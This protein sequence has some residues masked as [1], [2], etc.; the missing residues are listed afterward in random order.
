MTQ[1]EAARPGPCSTRAHRPR[2]PGRSATSSPTCC[3][4]A[5]TTCAPGAASR[6]R[7]GCCLEALQELGVA[8][9]L[10]RASL[11]IGC[12]TSFSSDDRRRPRAGAARARPVGRHRREAHAARHG[13][14]HPAGRRRHGER[15]AAGGAAHRRARRARHL[16][17]AEQRRVRRDRRAHDRD[18]RASAS[19]PRTR[20]TGATPSTTATRSSSAT[21]SRGLR[22]RRTWRAARCTTRARWRGR[23]GCASGRSR[24]SSTAR[25][26]RS[27]RCSPCA[28]PGGSSRPPRG[29]DYMHDTLGEV[30]IMGELKVD[31]V[32]KTTE[33]LHEENVRKQRE[34][35]PALA[36]GGIDQLDG[37]RLPAGGRGVPRR[38]PGVARRAPDAGA[39]CAADGDRVHARDR[40]TCE[41]LRAWNRELAD[42]R[43]AAIAWPEEY[44]GRGA[45]IME[46]VVFAE[47]MHRVGRA[48]NGEPDRPVEHRAGDHAVR[49]RGA[50]AAGSSRACCGATTSGAR[51]SPSPTPAPTSRSLKTSRG[52]RRRPLRRQRPEDV[53]HARPPRELVRAARAHR[54]GRAEAQGHLVPA[55]RHV[56]AGRRGAAARRRSPASTSSTRSSSPTCA[57]PSTRCSGP[58]TRAGGWR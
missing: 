41:A 10:D 18:E 5:S 25:A 27:S 42:A 36:R 4:P 49:H 1:S 53:E 28:R 7:C 47:E 57:C 45:G 34:V 8:Q 46:Q 22:A 13:R 9:R 35:E 58:S 43:Y 14:V 54:P 6:S 32:V 26:S 23:S 29:P 50:E 31:G 38:V 16:H 52:A 39:A 37:L 15:G 11:G 20:S 51:D 56:A 40:R 21:C 33:E 44:G 48:R 55:R 17:P 2:T 24:P 30:H 19:A 3:S 12:Y